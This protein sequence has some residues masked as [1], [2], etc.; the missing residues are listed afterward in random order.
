MNIFEH[1]AINRY[2]SRRRLFVIDVENIVGGACNVTEQGAM[3][4]R[5]IL[6][7]ELFMRD[8]E[9]AII[10]VTASQA[11]YPAALA[12]PGKLLRVRFG[13]SGADLALIDALDPKKDATRYDEVIFA[14]GDGI[15]AATASQFAGL[16]TRVAAIAHPGGFSPALRL[17]VHD[18]LYFKDTYEDSWRIA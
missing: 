3:W 7:K 13:E 15:F 1:G 10:A 16:G 12:F 6:R 2:G 18:T 11:L 9:H 14:S 8:E 5:E 4:A 17:A